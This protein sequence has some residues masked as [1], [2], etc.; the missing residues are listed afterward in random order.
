MRRTPEATA[1]SPAS[2]PWAVSSRA[3][4]VIRNSL[5]APAKTEWRL[6]GSNILPVTPSTPSGSEAM[7]LAER[8]ITRT[9]TPRFNNSLTVWLPTVPVPPITTVFDMSDLLA[10]SELPV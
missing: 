6:S 3:S 2:I 9:S 8:V 1:A 5:S 10:F 4:G 7:R